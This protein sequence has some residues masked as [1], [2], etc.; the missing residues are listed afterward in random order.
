[1]NPARSAPASAAAATS[2]SRVRPQTLTS[3]RE[4][5][6]ASFSPG[7]GA[8]MRAEPT[9]IASAPASSASAPWARE[10]MPLSAT[11]TRSPGTR[12]TSSSWSR[13][14]I[15][16]VERSRALIP[17]ISAPSATARSS[18]AASCASTRASRPSWAAVS[19]SSRIC[20]S[21]RSR[22]RRSTASAPRRLSSSSSAASEKK[23]LASRGRVAADL[24]A[25]RS[26]G[27]P[28]NR[29]STKMETA[30]AFLRSNSVARR[31]G[32]RVRPQVA[33]GRRAPFHLG[34]GAQA[35]AGECIAKSH[36]SASWACENA[37]S[38]SSRSPAAPESI[39]SRASPTP[40]RRSAA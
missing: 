28:P 30:A 22:R 38:S 18:S 5:S 14:S 16:K 36:A 13:R 32:I 37:I 23:P 10:A 11:T 35:R 7:S 19:R 20:E 39:A 8:R 34:D 15:S 40:S 12:S 21:S 1:M 4:T 31:A 9:R 6:S 3:G 26:A 2:S 25:C 24:A 17:M 33:G 27:D 29:S